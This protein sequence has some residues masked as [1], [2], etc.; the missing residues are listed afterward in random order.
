MQ[1]LIWM[2]A[3]CLK[4]TTGGIQLNWLIGVSKVHKLVEKEHPE[5][6]VH[7]TIQE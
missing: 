6:L 1:V 7:Q 3:K 2:V 5:G 4:K